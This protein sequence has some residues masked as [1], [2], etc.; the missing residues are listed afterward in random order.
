MLPIILSNRLYLV[1]SSLVVFEKSLWEWET[2]AVC[3]AGLKTAHADPSSGT[4]VYN[5]GHRKR[6]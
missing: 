1:K 4:S 6:K 2:G 5:C 3:V